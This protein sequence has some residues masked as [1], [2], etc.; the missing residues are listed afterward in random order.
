MSS[1]LL[2]TYD[3][4]FASFELYLS[5]INTNPFFSLFVNLDGHCTRF[6][7]LSMFSENKF[8]RL[9]YCDCDSLF[10]FVASF[11]S[12]C[13]TTNEHERQCECKC[14]F[15]VLKRCLYVLGRSL[16]G[17]IQSNCIF[18]RHKAELL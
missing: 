7:C 12:L 13:L 11:L 2:S 6:L 8:V 5:A 10:S 17:I 15:S 18:I 9:K 14:D 4:S 16:N 1:D 3:S